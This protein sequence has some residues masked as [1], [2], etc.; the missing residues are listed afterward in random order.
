MESKSI[1]MIKNLIYSFNCCYS[2]IYI[3]ISL[4][5]LTQSFVFSVT[6]ETKWKLVRNR[7]EV[8]AGIVQEWKFISLFK[9][10][11]WFMKTM[12]LLRNQNNSYKFFS[13]IKPLFHNFTPLEAC[14][15]TKGLR[16]STP[17]LISVCHLHSLD[18]I[19]L[20][21]LIIKPVNQTRILTCSEW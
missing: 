2:F 10:Y 21:L 17:N 7:T 20:Q 18:P 4:P 5:L 3:Y 6:L 1:S 8:N 11:L 15:D 9:Y 16:W 19:I 13:T 14:S 12:Y